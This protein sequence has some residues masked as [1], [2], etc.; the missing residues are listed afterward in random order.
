MALEL[1]REPNQQTAQPQVAPV[2]VTEQ[3]VQADPLSDATFFQAAS[4]VLFAE[5]LEIAKELGPK[6]S[7][8]S[9]D[10]AGVRGSPNQDTTRGASSHAQ[11]A[12]NQI[13]DLIEARK[14][15]ALNKDE[16][17]KQMIR[18]LTQLAA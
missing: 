15:F 11:G 6:E 18:D 5:M 16:L 9:I 1:Q 13:S 3:V 12:M 17:A 4:D 14:T 2:P 10:A 7:E 8:M